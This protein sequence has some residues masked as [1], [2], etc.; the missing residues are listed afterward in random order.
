VLD[1]SSLKLFLGFFEKQ[2][3]IKYTQTYSIVK[4]I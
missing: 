4:A 2:L 1:F 3:P